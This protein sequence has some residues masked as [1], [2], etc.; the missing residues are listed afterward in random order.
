MR[1]NLAI[2]AVIAIICASFTACGGKPSDMDSGV[3][4]I[5]M[6]ALETA[7]RYL[8]MDITAEEAETSIKE[9]EDRFDELGMDLT[10]TN[11]FV[12]SDVSMLRHLFLMVRLNSGTYE[13][14]LEKRD[15]LAKEL[16][17][18]ERND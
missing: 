17:E 18:S 3:Y 11:F 8:D 13:E 7:D 16:G 12:S 2:I 1:R 6:K 14:V 10:G 15:E 5:G 4:N 9:Y